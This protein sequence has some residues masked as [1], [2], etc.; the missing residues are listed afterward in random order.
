MSAAPASLDTGFVPQPVLCVTEHLG[1][2][3]AVAEA[4]CEG[5]FTH[6][7]VT[8]A[9]GTRPDWRSHPVAD[10]EWR[11]E[12]VKLYEG[13]DLAHAYTLTGL[14][15][16]LDTWQDLVAS[17]C[18]QVPVGFDTADV[19]GRRLLNWLYAWQRLTAAPDYPGLRPGLAEVLRKRML[20]DADH[21][22]AH[23]TP[24]RN[25]RTLELYAV[26]LVAL[27]I[28]RDRSRAGDALEQL[29]ANAATDIRLDGV[30]RE[31]S[32]DYHH[33]VLRSFLGAIANARRHGLTPPAVLLDRAGRAADFA[34]HSQRP[35]GWTPAV[36]DGDRGDFRAL[37]TLA[38]QVLDRPELQWAA[39]AGAAGRPPS[40]CAVDFPAGGYH[41][42]RSGWGTTRPYTEERFALLDCGPIGDGGHGHYD[43][44]SVELY[45]AGRA[46]VVDPGRYTYDA[47]DGSWRRR[48][49]GTAAHNTVTVDELDQIPYRPGKPRGPLSS[50]RLLSR[51]TR[52]GLDLIAGEVRSPAY[53]AVHVRILVLVDDDYWVVH[54][55]L[56]APSAHRYQVRWHL[57]A[58]QAM[59]RLTPGHNQ[60]SVG[61]DGFLLV[62]IGGRTAVEPGWVSYDYGVKL[63]APVLTVTADPGRDADLVTVLLPG[64]AQPVMVTARH[65]DD[66]SEIRVHR[67]GHTIDRLSWGHDGGDV[68]W[69][70]TP[71]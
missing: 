71:C 65:L 14:P 47:T 66:R 37:L 45:A 18:D 25:H 48:F 55:R 38:S 53:D 12:W 7:G 40:R 10:V 23:L 24:E 46:M 13:L 69:R 36:S 4:A 52:P 31:A 59:P 43:Q 51:T 16:H 61:A 19:T 49:K 29:A 3:L 54:D 63:P 56:R 5:S 41:V 50:A 34:L 9:L 2:S 57:D 64:R 68:T 28:G 33:I 20:A 17:F 26:L 1:R 11:L 35:D 27:A 42:Q 67:P 44:L 39:T 30:H 58:D 62:S 8:I 6:H 22:A 70:R 60:T 15:R 21:L 32:T